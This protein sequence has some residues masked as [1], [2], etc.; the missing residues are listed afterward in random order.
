MRVLELSDRRVKLLFDSDAFCKLGVAGLLEPCA[1]LFGVTLQECGRLPALPHMLR[2]G[3]LV[4]LYGANTCKQ[5]LSACARMPSVPRVSG[6]TLTMLATQPGIDPGEALLIAQIAEHGGW[7]V[8][9]DKRCLIPLSGIPDLH[10]KLDHR[11]ATIEGVLLALSV[12]KNPEE[13]RDSI[14]RVRPY[15]T[16]IDICVLPNGLPS[17]E[18]LRSYHCDAANKALPLRLWTPET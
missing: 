5:L 1:D 12:H 7:V 6:P 15:D 18:G 9:G 16:S 4:H 11:I 10:P 17:I 3:R 8:S 13:M 14:R 2:R